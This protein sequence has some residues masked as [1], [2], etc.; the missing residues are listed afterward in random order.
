MVPATSDRIPRVPP[1]S[2]YCYRLPHLRLRGYHTLWPNFPVLFY[3]MGI[4]ISQSYNPCTAVTATGLGCFRFARHYSGNH[5]CFL[6]LRLL[7][8]FSSAGLLSLRS[9][10]PSACRVA[11]F[12]NLRI[13][14]C[15]PIPAAYRSLLRPSSPPRAKASPIRSYLLPYMSPTPFCWAEDPFS[16]P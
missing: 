4:K 7:R 8:C 1:Y 5:C 14:S 2:G 10:R 13:A 3:F 9:D 6:L 12:G 16:H 11:P 15:L